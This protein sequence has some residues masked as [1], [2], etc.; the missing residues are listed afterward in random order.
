MKANQK[1]TSTIAGQYRPIRGRIMGPILLFVTSLAMAMAV[2]AQDD[3]SFFA[4][5]HVGMTIGQC[6]TYYRRLG[7]GS[8]VHSGA[9]QGEV[10]VEFRT[11]TDPQRPVYVYYRKSNGKIV[12]VTYSKMGD[13][14]RFPKMR[15]SPSPA[16]IKEAV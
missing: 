6:E 1:R 11:S 2:Q 13:T 4:G 15:F 8:L 5:A 16:S 9:P 10:Q 7:I 3:K 14:R 12:S